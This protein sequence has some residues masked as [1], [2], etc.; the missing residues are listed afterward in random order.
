M[1][2]SRFSR[3]GLSS[4]FTLRSSN[5]RRILDASFTGDP[6]EID[7]L[8]ASRGGRSERPRM[9]IEREWRVDGSA[10]IKRAFRRDNSRVVCRRERDIG[11]VLAAVFK[12]DG[13]TRDEET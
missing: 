2:N 11:A 8:G 4:F 12:R 5:E 6:R 3:R 10:G 13:L 1:R 9:Q 7:K